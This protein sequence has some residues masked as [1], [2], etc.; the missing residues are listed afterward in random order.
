MNNSP[1]ESN[2]VE[3]GLAHLTKRAHLRLGLLQEPGE[4]LVCT[5]AVPF[6]VAT[7]VLGLWVGLN[8][9]RTGVLDY[10]AGADLVWSQCGAGEQLLEEKPQCLPLFRNSVEADPISGREAIFMRFPAAGGFVPVDATLSDGARH[11]AAGTGFA[12]CHVHALPLQVAGGASEAGSEGTWVHDGPVYRCME[13]RQLRFDGETFSADAVKRFHFDELFPGW[14]ISNKAMTPA[15]MS[16]ESLLWP[17]A[18]RR[19]LTDET[20]DRFS[21]QS[22]IGVSR[23]TFR[24]DGWGI[25]YIFEVEPA[26]EGYEP[27]MVRGPENCLLLTAR[28]KGKGNVPDKFGIPCWQSTDDG[29]TWSEAFRVQN[30]RADSPLVIGATASGSNFV[31]A[32][33]YAGGMNLR[34]PGYSRELLALWE[35]KSGLDGL[36][37]ATI[38]RCG[39]WDFGKA[40][41]E[42]GWKLDHPSTC[43]IMDA[44]GN[45]RTLLTY[46]VQSSDENRLKDIGASNCSGVHLEEINL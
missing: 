45:Q 8:K 34:S 6:Q 35:L 11:P 23:W 20:E 43:I 22:S 18:C 37:P 13:L 21:T 41:T 16:G 2:F 25:E 27:S 15:V 9:T 39:Q 40:P 3:N 28:R 36:G 30:H 33:L 7:G 32:N 46:R 10:A 38:L 31:V 14:M 19:S 4:G 26:F 12:F 5:M 44:D 29:K 42:H 17:L 24:E 1:P